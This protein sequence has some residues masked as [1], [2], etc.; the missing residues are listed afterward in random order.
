[1]EQ[2]EE[3]GDL[4]TEIRNPRTMN[5]DVLATADL[6]AALH[7]ENFSIAESVAQALP[8]IAMAVDIIS[9]RLGRGG[10]LFYVGAGTSGRLGVLDA[11]ECPPTFSVSNDMVQ[12]VIAGGLDA[13]T[14]SI[15]GAEDCPEAGAEDLKSRGVGALDVV[16]GIAAS[17]RTPYVAGALDLATRCG[18]ASIALVN[19]SN[20]LLSRHADITISALTGPEALTGSTRLKA[21]TAQKLVLNLLT[22]AAMVRLG[23]AYSNLMVDVRATNTK[24]RD[25]AIRIV[26]AA[27]DVDWASAEIAV[28]DADWRTKA[29]IVMLKCGVSSEEANRR[30]DLAGGWVAK[31]IEM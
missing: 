3:L 21:G 16:V 4:E 14:N 5:L 27:A 1:M 12:G 28:K 10:R 18:A 30:L 26:M 15:E 8:Q 11:S 24:L 6:V 13:L 2:L 25:R 17:G 29:A 23:K 19:V 31:A 9:D 22:T 20:S 7:A